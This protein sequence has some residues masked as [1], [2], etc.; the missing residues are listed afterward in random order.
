MAVAL[1]FRKALALGTGMALALG[2]VAE[3]ARLRGRAPRAA[4]VGPRST[5]D[6]H[7][8]WEACLGVCKRK[9]SALGCR[10]LVRERSRTAGAQSTT[11]EPAARVTHVPIRHE[12][13]RVESAIGL[14]PVPVG[15]VDWTGPDRFLSVL[16]SDRTVN[17]AA[18]DRTGSWQFCM[19][20]PEVTV[21]TVSSGETGSQ[22]LVGAWNE[23]FLIHK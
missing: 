16:G 14:T 4:L 15:T 19:L 23:G 18:Q 12:E 2:I 6:L 3:Q 13:K 11:S 5:L 9:S 20:S 10:Q 17:I 21:R 22:A 7:R 8:R 1:G